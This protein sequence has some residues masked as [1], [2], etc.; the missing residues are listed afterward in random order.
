L[1]LSLIVH[2]RQLVTKEYTDSQ[3]TLVLNNAKEYTDSQATLVLN[4]A[5]E[6]TDSQNVCFSGSSDNRPSDV[7]VGRYYFDTDL[8]HPI[9][10]NG[11]DWTNANGE[12]V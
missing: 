1:E 2:D 7:G 5:K 10:F 3:A 9:W 4:N 8:G 12:V 11:S 6:Y